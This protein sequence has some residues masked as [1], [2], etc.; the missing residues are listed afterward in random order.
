MSGTSGRWGVA[1]VLAGVAMV[2]V[3]CKAVPND[4]NGDKKADFVYVTPDGAWHRDG[5]DGLLWGGQPTDLSV[6]GDYTGAG[7]WQPAVLRGKDWITRASM[8]PIHYDPAGL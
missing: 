1:A 8:S 5:L 3:A 2:A 6:P 4:Y 7:I